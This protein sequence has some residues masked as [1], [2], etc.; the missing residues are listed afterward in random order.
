MK[1][2]NGS[3]PRRSNLS[4]PRQVVGVAPEPQPAPAAFDKETEQIILKKD[5]PSVS[6]GVQITGNKVDKVW[7]EIPRKAGLREG[8]VVVAVNGRRHN[9]TS[10]SL[11]SHDDIIH[12]LRAST[13]IKLSV[14]RSVQHVR[15]EEQV[16]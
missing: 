5:D 2:S 4:T 9:A 12:E 15:P 11:I 3:I 13:E 7:G 1:S 10:G 8:D 6:L 14:C 16:A